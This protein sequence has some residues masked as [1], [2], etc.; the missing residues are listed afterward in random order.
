MINIILQPWIELY[1]QP[2]LLEPHYPNFKSI[3]PKAQ[4]FYAPISLIETS[5]YNLI[6]V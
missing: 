4:R 6:T 2:V 3:E 1:F 5:E